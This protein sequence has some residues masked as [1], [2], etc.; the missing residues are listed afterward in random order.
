[1]AFRFVRWAYFRFELVSCMHGF[2]MFKGFAFLAS[3]FERSSLDKCSVY[4]SI[5]NE[6]SCFETKDLYVFKSSLFAIT[7]GR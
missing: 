3:E 1:M 4:Y 6:C 2:L 5:L 7:C